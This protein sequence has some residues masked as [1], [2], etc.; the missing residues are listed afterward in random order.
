MNI[1]VIYGLPSRVMAELSSQL[2]KHE[3]LSKMLFYTDKKYEK[4]SILNQKKISWSKLKDK[5]IFVGRRVPIVLKISGAFI[6]FRVFNCYPHSTGA[7]IGNVEIDVDIIVHKDCLN[8]IHGA[9]DIVIV[10]MVNEALMNIDMSTLGRVKV[11]ETYDIRDIPIEYSGYTVKF[12][13]QGFV[14]YK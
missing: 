10:E 12:M 11:L 14:N 4:E 6:S 1:D 5:N 8:T 2:F 13:V 9:R 3:H 7:G